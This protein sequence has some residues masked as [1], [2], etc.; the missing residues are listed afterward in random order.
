VELAM[1]AVTQGFRHFICVGG[2]GTLHELVNGLMRQKV[3]RPE[4]FKVGII[5]IGTGNDWARQFNIPKSSEK[6]IKKIKAG[7]AKALDIG[8][9]QLD[10]DAAEP[11]YFNN[12]VGVGFDGHVIKTI[13]RFKALGPLAYLIG[14]LSGLFTYRKFEAQIS[15]KDVSIQ[16]SCLMIVA[17]LGRFAGGGMQLTSDPD[18]ADGYFDLSVAGNMKRFQVLLLFRSLFNGKITKSRFVQTDKIK[19][20]RVEV[21]GSIQPVIEA[22]G[23]LVGSGSFEISILPRALKFIT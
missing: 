4:E 18:T 23:E 8:C 10:D 7:Q 19:D 13:S 9:I 2:D 14:A 21:T 6:A 5:P 22:D 20:L 16:S 1:D 17:G 15:W 3:I 12:L 11:V